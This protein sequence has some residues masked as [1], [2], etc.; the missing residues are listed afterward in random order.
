MPEPGS[1][2]D[3]PAGEELKEVSWLLGAEFQIGVL[4][5]RS[6]ISAVIA[7]SRSAVF[8]SALQALESSWRLEVDDRADMVLVGVGARGRVPTSEDLAEAVRQGL[9]VVRHG[10]KLILLSQAA[11]DVVSEAFSRRIQKSDL[12]RAT[13]WAD[14]FLFS[15]ALPDDIEELGLV[16][17]ERPAN[18]AKLAAHAPSLILISQA[19][20]VDA[21][22]RSEASQP[23]S[24]PLIDKKRFREAR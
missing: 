21:R 20:R 4:P 10:G 23:G 11:G 19:D 16:P 8:A 2:T 15:K 9:R 6:G 22:V 12:H 7:G 17:L 18:V 14:V 24:A 1:T 13:S 3:D 5:A